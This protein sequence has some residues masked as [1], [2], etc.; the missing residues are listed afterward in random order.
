MLLL[1][2]KGLEIRPR[3]TQIEVVMK[4]CSTSEHRNHPTQ[5]VA[6]A[7]VYQTDSAIMNPARNQ[8]RKHKHLLQ[9]SMISKV[10]LELIK[11]EERILIM[12]IIKQDPSVWD[13]MTC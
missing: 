10:N 3:E 2:W 4:R 1:N 12:D 5:V 6:S 9:P 13:V 8:L 7:L 11:L